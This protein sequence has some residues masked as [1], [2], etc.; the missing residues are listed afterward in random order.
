MIASGSTNIPTGLAWGWRVISPGEPFTDGVDYDDDETIKAI[1]LLTDGE[2]W[3]G[4]LNNHN[5]A[6][7]NAYGYVANGRLG[8]SN[9][10]DAKDELDNRTAELCENIKAEDVTIYTLTFDLGNGPIKDLMEAC[11]T[12]PSHY[13]DANNSSELAESFSAIATDLSNLRISK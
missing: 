9:P 13:Y 2:N 6:Y 10:S 3:L 5:K 1:V 12:S 8:T 11:A 4:N 7:Y